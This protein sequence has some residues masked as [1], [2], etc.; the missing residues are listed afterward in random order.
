MCLSR[1][2]LLAFL[3]A[4][5]VG[6]LLAGPLDTMP[7]PMTSELDAQK[8]SS[9][10]EAPTSRLSEQEDPA[11]PSPTEALENLESEWLAFTEEWAR[12]YPT[13]EALGIELGELPSYLASLEKSLKDERDAS[14]AER[15]AYQKDLADRNMEIEDL[16]KRSDILFGISVGVGGVSVLLVLMLIFR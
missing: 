5:S 6:S 7:V 14:E 4:S 13:L 12:F 10:C 15:D 2:L 11:K 16:K 8:R 1:S 3:L 9:E